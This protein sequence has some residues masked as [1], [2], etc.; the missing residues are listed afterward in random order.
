MTDFM[1]KDFMDKYGR[2]GSCDDELANVLST[3]LK[4][5]VTG[6]IDEKNMKRVA[7]ENNVPL[8]NW[9]HLRNGHRRMLLG[10]VLRG[11]LRRGI[12][13]IVGKKTV[14]PDPKT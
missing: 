11:N 12:P 5:P 13:V 1:T 9:D 3:F 10:N 6:R 14:K 4:D 7:R 2:S 8:S